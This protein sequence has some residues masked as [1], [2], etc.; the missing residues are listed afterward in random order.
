[1]MAKLL[2]LAFAFAVLLTV[3][4]VAHSAPV[5]C[6]LATPMP[7][8][9]P[10]N[11]ES[12]LVEDV[13]M[14]CVSAAPSESVVIDIVLT[15][16][17]NL[18][19][20]I[21]DT[22]TLADEALLLID[23]PKPGVANTSNGFAYFGQVLGTPGVLA[24]QPGSGN[25]YQ[26]IQGMS[27]G[28]VLENEVVFFG[29]PYVT[30]GTR[31]FR[32]TNTRANVAAVGINPV[33]AIVGITSDFAIDITNPEVTVAHGAKA[34]SFTSGPIAGAIGLDLSF[35][36][37]FPAAFKKRIEN[38]T[39]GPMT[40]NHQD[41]P[42][43]SHCTESGFTPG[44]ES[45]TAHAIGFADTGVRLL[46][47][48]KDIPAGVSTLT[49]PNQVISS[50]GDLVAHRVLPP[51]GTHFAAGTV[52]TATGNSTVSVSATHTAELLYDVTAA[53]PYLG[54]NGCATLDTFH[55]GVI[56][57]LPVSMSSTVVTGEL[58]PLD[59]VGEASATE[60]EPRFVP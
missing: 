44:F 10:A 57:S 24:G 42:G 9:V 58:A 60:P 49:V 32:L 14:T 38:R 27:G 12:E 39:S 54:V 22:T 11:G 30:G 48:F 20:R 8:A 26:G 51:L 4:P 52:T 23:D 56:P 31:T 59:S 50:S 7:P 5:T 15:L 36:E 18:T 37:L 6:T 35:V 29:V 19:S 2:L 3:V 25:V 16:N 45:L 43:T 40:H 21:T 46:A 1:M 34:L 41:K 28:V 13:V 53:S 33:N 55:I 17:V 47:Q